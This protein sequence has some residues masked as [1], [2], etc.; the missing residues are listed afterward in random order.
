MSFLVTHPGISRW[1]RR[2]LAPQ[3]PAFCG[4]LILAAGCI[5]GAMG[6]GGGS[7]T[8]VAGGTGGSTSKTSS[9]S[10][11]SGSSSSGAVGVLDCAWNAGDNCWKSTVAPALSCLPPSTQKGTLSAD[12]KTCTYTGGVTIAF[13]SPLDI[14]PN[15]MTPSFTLTD[16]GALCLRLDQMATGFTLTTSAGTVSVTID[17]SKDAITVTCPDGAAYTGTASLLSACENDLPTS[18]TSEAFSS[19]DAGNVDQASL[20]LK[21]TSEGKVL[22]FVCSNG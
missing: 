5:L 12:A 6:C 8:M 2:F 3:T 14:S 4:G 20:S 17:Q 16:G 7:G 1:G 19:T 11:A 21:G 22:V 10:T 15:L 13:P 9:S 18:D